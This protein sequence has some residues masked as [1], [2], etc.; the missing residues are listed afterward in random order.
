MFDDKKFKELIKIR[1]DTPD[2]WD[3]GCQKV[4]NEMVNLISNNITDSINYV[5]EQCTASEFSW[6]S[7]I[8]EEIVEKTLS[9]EFINAL[10]IT[11]KKYPIETKKYHID[12]AIVSTQER[13]NF[14]IDEDK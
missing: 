13:L 2:E 12:D 8:F 9:Q 5:L 10:Y 14:L 11:A 7:E 4:N 3:Y 1:E 6:L